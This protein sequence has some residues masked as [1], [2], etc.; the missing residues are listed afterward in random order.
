MDH[1]SVGAHQGK[2]LA[3]IAEFEIRVQ[4]AVGCHLVALRSE[5]DETLAS[6]D[7]DARF[8]I[9][10]GFVGVIGSKSLPFVEVAGA[11]RQRPAL[12]VDRQAAEVEQFDPIGRFIIII[13]IW[14]KAADVLGLGVGHELA[15]QQ[16]A[17]NRQFVDRAVAANVIGDVGRRERHVVGS[18]RQRRGN[19]LGRQPPGSVA[20]V[21][22]RVRV[23]VDRQTQ[24]G[25]CLVHRAGQLGR[26]DAGD[27]LID[28]D[29]R[30]AVDIQFV[31]AA[32]G[33]HIAGLVGGRHQH[34][35]NP[36]GQRRRDHVVGQN[37]SSVAVVDCLKTVAADGDHNR[38]V[39]MVDD[40]SP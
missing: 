35:V 10:A 30:D 28:R 23:A 2:I 31:G 16:R 8:G 20:V 17:A 36:V 32:V 24:R 21:D 33:S 40:R 14:Y 19:S 39:E 29:D 3:P 18:F 7:R 12:Q 38:S 9:A 5:H 22:R 11:V 4:F 37:P 15:D 13:A 25:R 1:L 26:R 27:Q 34:V 6:S